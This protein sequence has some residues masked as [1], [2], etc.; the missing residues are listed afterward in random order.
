MMSNNTNFCDHPEEIPKFL[1]PLA[2]IDWSKRN[3]D[4][5]GRILEQIT[6]DKLKVLT[7]PENKQLFAI[8]L[9]QILKIPLNNEEKA[10]EN[11]FSSREKQNSSNSNGK[12]PQAKKPDTKEKAITK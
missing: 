2:Q 4:W 5:K 12:N 6:T 7:R 3:P 1:T 8:Y 11:Q 10:L 9:K